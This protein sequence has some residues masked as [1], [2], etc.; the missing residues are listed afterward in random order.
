MVH[1]VSDVEFAMSVTAPNGLIAVDDYLNPDWPG[2]AE[3][4]ARMY[5]MGSHAFVPL[6]YCCGKLFLCSLSYHARYLASIQSYIG[7]DHPETRLKRE[8]RLG[9][10]TLSVHPNRTGWSD[11]V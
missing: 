5:L 1:T 4:M 9:F 11:L 10:D 2:V 6:A 8:P 3:A 7:A